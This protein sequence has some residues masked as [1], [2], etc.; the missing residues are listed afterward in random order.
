MGSN[1]KPLI[2]D[3][4]LGHDREMVVGTDSI[5]PAFVAGGSGLGDVVG[6]A[7]ATDLTV[8]RF[9]GVSGK[10][11]Q[12][13]GVTVSDTNDVAGVVGLTMTGNLTVSGT[14]DG[15]NV[16][17]DGIE[18]D[19]HLADPDPHSGVL[20]LDGTRPMTGAL[21]MGAQA[22]TNVGNVD[23]V[24]V[25]AL[26]T[27]VAAIPASITAAVLTET[28]N[29]VADVDAE[30]TAR[31]AADAVLTSAVAAIDGAN[32][33][34]TGD[35]IP[36]VDE[37]ELFIDRT[38]DDLRFRTI[39]GEQGLQAEVVGNSVRIKR[40]PRIWAPSARNPA[41]S[42]QR[43][44]AGGRKTA[45]A[46]GTDA[47]T[48]PNYFPADL[49]SS[50]GADHLFP[51][52]VWTGVDTHGYPHK[53][54]AGLRGS[55]SETSAVEGFE[56]GHDC[57]AGAAKV[58]TGFRW[59]LS[60]G[61]ENAGW[62]DAFLEFAVE[63]NPAAGTYNGPNL[64]RMLSPELDAT[65]AGE[66]EWDGAIELR[67]TGPQECQY[68][69]RFHIYAAS[70]AVLREW[71]RRGKLTTDH[72]WLTDDARVQLRWRVDK[73]LTRADVFTGEFQGERQDANTLRLHVD[74]YQFDPIG[75]REE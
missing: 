50:H 73:D 14:V 18:L 52:M 57:P 51:Y 72:D 64:M 12:A 65:W 40:R 37:L 47:S 22:I 62:L 45:G 66:L 58:G 67:V 70:G 63:I 34:S 59:L 54:H 61:V 23:G 2:Y 9:D 3:P 21:D 74:S 10:T 28:N 26:S 13:S 5:H 32:V 7:S 15:R 41:E 24:D 6:P 43:V 4:A 33:A 29:R 48:G 25:A 53:F 17:D 75:F 19:G 55:Y 69:G 31:I 8:P 56:W 49:T 71:K 27:T 20:P 44:R 46:T 36:P 68:E 42:F 39:A 16:S 35:N 30:E 60:G 11:L 38:G 1:A